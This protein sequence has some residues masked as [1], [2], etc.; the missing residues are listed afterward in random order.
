MKYG[1]SHKRTCYMCRKEINAPSTRDWPW[2]KTD[3]RKDSETKGRVLY[4]CTEACQ[5]KF[6]TDYPRKT[7][8]RVR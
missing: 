8:N 3:W 1:A 2:K 5:K 4:F 6:E 7:Y